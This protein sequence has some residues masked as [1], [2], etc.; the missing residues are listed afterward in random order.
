MISKTDSP[1]LLR[2]PLGYINT[3]KHTRSLPTMFGIESFK[4]EDKNRF[5]G[6]PRNKCIWS[7]LD[8]NSNP[9]LRQLSVDRQLLSIVQNKAYNQKLAQNPR[10]FERDYKELKVYL[11]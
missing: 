11:F 8:L 6:D 3:H 5:R 7:R 1:L 10:I 2:K 4:G 9:V